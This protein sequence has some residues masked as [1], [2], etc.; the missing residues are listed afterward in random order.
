MKALITLTIDITGHEA[1]IGSIP[2][3]LPDFQPGR[4]ILKTIYRTRGMAYS[5]FFKMDL[6][7]RLGFVS[8][9]LLLSGTDLLSRHQAEHCGIFLMNSTS[10]LDTDEKHQETIAARDSYFP[11][12]SI[13]VYTLPNIM[14]G[15][16]AIRH[17]IKGENMVLISREP[18]ADLLQSITDEAFRCGRITAAIVGWADA[19]HDTLESCFLLAEA[20][21]KAKSG[22][23][24]RENVIFDAHN[25]KDLFAHARTNG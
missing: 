20:E 9:E 22:P 16:I 21:H 15:E 7:S 3:G 18:D 2:V 23:G 6:L 13:F 8:A 10:S 17:G 14:A 4:A 5:K 19:W 11:S 1:R 25:L 24:K 12:P